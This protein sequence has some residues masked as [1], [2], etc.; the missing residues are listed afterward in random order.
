MD[1]YN[2]NCIIRFIAQLSTIYKYSSDKTNQ[3]TNQPQ[4]LHNITLIQIV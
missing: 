3:P 2:L 4:T 1:A